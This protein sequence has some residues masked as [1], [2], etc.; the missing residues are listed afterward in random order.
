MRTIVGVGIAGALGAL[1][2]YGLGSLVNE[3]FPNFPWGTL[4]INVSGSLALGFLFVTLTERS[5]MSASTRTILTI[6]F[7]GAYTTFSTFSLETVRLFEDGAFL[8]AGANVVLNVVLG[9]SAAAAG[10]GLARAIA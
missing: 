10:V 3:R 5:L 2:R 1:A 7:L 9:L 4:L 8:A 6:G